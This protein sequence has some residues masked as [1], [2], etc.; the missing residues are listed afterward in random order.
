MNLEEHVSRRILQALKSIPEQDRSDIYVISLFVYDEDDDPRRPTVTVGFNTKAR[1]A[2]CTPAPGRP[3]GFPIAS[4]LSEAKWNYA[5]WLQNSLAVICGPEEDSTGATLLS[6]WARKNGYWYTD[7]E[8]AADLEAMLE[9][10]QP[11]AGE[12]VEILV[13]VVQELHRSAEITVL[14]GRPL[15]VLIHELEYY[16]AIADQNVRANPLSLVREF[17][18]WVNEGQ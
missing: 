2:E 6:T 18:T 11:L 14:L 8:E 9:R 3:S 12:F 4:S 17:A 5:F 10:V 1:V 15:P 7:E 16:E 13:Q